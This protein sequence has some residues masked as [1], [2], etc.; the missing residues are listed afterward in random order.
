MT[1]QT[2][3]KPVQHPKPY[4]PVAPAPPPDRPTGAL[5]PAHAAD[6]LDA[7]PLLDHRSRRRTVAAGLAPRGHYLALRDGSGTRLLRLD[8]NVT[9]IGRGS[10]ADIG[11]DEHRVSRTH[12]VFVRH[13]R[14]FR[15]LDNR[16]SNGT[17]VN[18]RQITAT[19]LDNGDVILVGPVVLQYLV[20]S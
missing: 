12:A 19:N 13:G 5:E 7:L 15:L 14:Y 11:L 2:P 8:G 17:F 9:H 16:S 10:E 6:A 4:G 1:T 18:G 20:V 3:S